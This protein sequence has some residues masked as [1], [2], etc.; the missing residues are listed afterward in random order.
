MSDAQKPLIIKD[1]QKAIADSPHLGHALMRNLDIEMY[2]G[3]LK[4][5]KKNLPLL[6]SANTSTFTFN[7]GTGN[8]TAAATL[9]TSAETA[10][11]ASFLGAAVYFTT[12][13]TLPAGLSLNTVYF[14]IYVDATTFGVAD[15]RAHADTAT[16]ISI[17]DSGSGVHT[18][19]P[20]APGTIKMI[21][22]DQNSGNYYAIDSNGR[23][24]STKSSNYFRLLLHSSI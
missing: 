24:W 21:K 7:S 17:T 6:I 8:G 3:A 10:A 11:S 19:H 13:G 23:V 16:R 20:I 14:L 15:S 4:P 12:T 2:P 5:Q 1:F 9:V 18:V 22:H